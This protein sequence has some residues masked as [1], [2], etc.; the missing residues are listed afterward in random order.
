MGKSYEAVLEQLLEAQNAH[1]LSIIKLSEPVSGPL[2]Q[3]PAERTS[4]VSADVF[5]NPTPASLEA[6]LA[7]YKVCRVSTWDCLLLT[8]Q[9]NYSR[10]SASPTSNRSPKRNLYA[11]LSVTLLLSWNTKTMLN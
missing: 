8:I 11:P 5:D 2:K 1:E 10:N 6:D 7:H 4:D 3:N 9:R